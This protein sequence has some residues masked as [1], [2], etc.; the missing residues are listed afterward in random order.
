MIARAAQLQ[1]DSQ[2]AYKELVIDCSAPST[3]P[4]RAWW[5][6]I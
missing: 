4:Q 6:T 2:K 5:T 3:S 1:D